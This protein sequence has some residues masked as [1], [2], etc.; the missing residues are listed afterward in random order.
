MNSPTAKEIAQEA[1]EALRKSKETPQEHFDRL[2]R[3][4]WINSRGE[5]TRL[6]GGDAEPE[7]SAPVERNGGSAKAE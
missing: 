6:F 1:R 5:I 3:L 7:I 4:G 2:V